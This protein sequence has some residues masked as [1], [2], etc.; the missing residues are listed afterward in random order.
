MLPNWARYRSAAPGGQDARVKI[1][2][3]NLRIAPPDLRYRSLP[4]IRSKTAVTVASQKITSDPDYGDVL[5]QEVPEC[6]Q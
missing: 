5:Y 4:E 6:R 1:P 2:V 3:E